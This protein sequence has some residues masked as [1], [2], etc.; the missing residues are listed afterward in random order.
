MTPWTSVVA[1]ATRPKSTMANG[2]SWWPTIIVRIRTV[3]RSVTLMLSVWLT[4]IAPIVWM[5][6]VKARWWWNWFLC[7]FRWFR[8]LLFRWFFFL[9]LFY[10]RW[11]IL[12]SLLN[13]RFRVSLFV[14][15]LRNFIQ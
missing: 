1:V 8:I 6:L 9:V 2:R 5:R 3:S 4:P 14:Q 10:D 13:L 7:G 15:I 12:L 11:W